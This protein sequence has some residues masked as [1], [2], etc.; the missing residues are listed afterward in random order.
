M[1]IK[2][3]RKT[4]PKQEADTKKAAEE[5]AGGETEGLSPEALTLYAT[6]ET[7]FLAACADG[8]LDQEEYDTL[9]ASFNTWTG[10]DL[11]AE[12]LQS[13]F[14]VFIGALNEEGVE[15]CIARAA[16]HLDEEA[17]RAAFDF[18]AAITIISGDTSE[19]EIE[20]LKFIADAFEIPDEEARD[21]W[22]AVGE[23]LQD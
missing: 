22:I 18:A 20:G 23:S 9:G 7:G 1:P 3:K 4:T 8:E 15:G 2:S 16:S 21:R 5:L 19:E 6:L 11:D 14:E 12:A 10:A 13:L 17:R